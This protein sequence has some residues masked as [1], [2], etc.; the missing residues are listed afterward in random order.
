MSQ[1]QTTS[2]QIARSVF[3]KQQQKL[4]ATEK[5][6]A[7]TNKKLGTANKKLDTAS[8]K[9]TALEEEL[10]TYD[11]E[12]HLLL[13]RIQFLTLKLAHAEN[14]PEQVALKMELNYLQEQ[15]SNHVSE[16]FG[17]SRSERR[18]NA[19]KSNKR[20]KKKKKNGSPRKPKSPPVQ[21]PIDEFVSKRDEEEACPCCGD[22]LHEVEGKTTD[23]DVTYTITRV[24]RKRRHKAHHYKC[25]SCGTARVAP[26]PTGLVRKNGKYDI[27]IIAM[28][29]VDKYQFH[30]PIER[31]VVKMAQEGLIVTNQAMCDQLKALVRWL[32]PAYYALHAELMQSPYLHF[33]LSHWRHMSNTGGSKKW[34]MAS[35]SNNDISYFSTLP[36]KGHKALAYLFKGY[37][38]IVVSDGEAGLRK[39]EKARSRK[40]LDIWEDDSHYPDFVSA[41]CWPH[42]RRGLFKAEKCGYPV[43]ECLDDIAE[44]FALEEEAAEISER[45]GKPLIEVRSRIRNTKSRALLDKIWRWVD[46]QRPEAKTKFEDAIGYIRRQWKYLTVFLDHPELPPDNNFAERELRDPVLGR[47]N[48]YGSRSLDGIH[49]ADVLY[50]LTRTCVHR[51][52]EPYDY[53]IRAFHAA[54][55]GQV[56]LP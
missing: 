15:L 20:R 32:D 14:R 7:A 6:L 22:K 54:Q 42:A 45:T 1:S 8:N 46:K 36:S 50:T 29:A 24:F 44:I 26:G 28:V 12:I 11:G 30:L 9:I 18:R 25:H 17:S 53:L 56:L 31:Q 41:G 10:S 40:T 4:A 23:H 16:K 48:H 33:D 52:V 39:L 35:L 34:H 37:D 2:R 5:R 19:D 49:V 38:G 51:G 27:S 21:L 3:E 47:K 55:A 13:E 43:G